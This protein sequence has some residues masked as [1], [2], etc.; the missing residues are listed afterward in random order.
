MIHV[1]R[2]SSIVLLA[3]GVFLGSWGCATSRGSEG[4][5]AAGS[6]NLIAA[7]ELQDPGL[8][9][10]NALEAIRRLRPRWVRGRGAAS[11]APAAFLNGSP[12]SGLRTLETVAVTDNVEIRFGEARDAA[13][14]YG[15][16][17]PGG[18][19]DVRTGR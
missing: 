19:I 1:V 8:Q 9:A 13:N 5:A 18:V 17:Y 3:A 15:G 4:S 6:R 14:Q 12:F 2:V 10:L 16:S 11:R 7:D